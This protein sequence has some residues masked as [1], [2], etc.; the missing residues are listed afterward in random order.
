MAFGDLTKEIYVAGAAGR[1][2]PLPTDP[3]R[4]EEAARYVMSAEAFGYVS[5]SAG[6]GATGTA[7][8]SA[9]DR[10][11]LVPRILRDVSRRDLAVDLFGHRLPAPVVLAPIGA[12]GLVHPRG[13]RESIQAAQALG[14]P[15]VLS[16]VSSIGMEDVAAAAADAVRWFQ[17][18][19]L[20]DRAVTASLVERAEAAGYSAV[21]VTA[22]TPVIGYRP[23]DLDAAFLPALHGHGCVNIIDDPVFRAG[24]PDDAGHSTVLARWSEVFANPGLSWDDIGWLRGRTRL[25]IVLKGVL[26]PSDAARAKDLGVDG[27][28]VSTHGGRQVDGTIA[29]LDALPAVRGEVGDDFPVLFDSG[30]RTG[31]D[32]MKALALGA[33]AVLYGRPYVYG[34]ALGGRGGVEHVLR[35]LLAE[36]DLALAGCG[37]CGV[38]DLTRDILAPG[39][40]GS[41]HR[42]RARPGP[43][44][45]ERVEERNH[46]V[47][48]E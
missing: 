17:L 22:D 32:V 20:S 48:H 38:R 27:I 29:A 36:L 24:L 37:C 5:G 11:Q 26:H 15:F 23:I 28:V 8:R 21:V 13:E 46:A 19:F 7:N 41:A 3:T 16:T 12:Q 42:G 45:T 18:Y 1:R 43:P 25:P 31:V 4:L 35:C 2:P 9:F 14:L 39:P 40:R 6:T 34:L 44:E 10:W 30:V 47:S 33:D